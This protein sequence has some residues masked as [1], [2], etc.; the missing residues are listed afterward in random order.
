[1]NLASPFLWIP[2]HWQFGVWVLLTMA[3]LAMGNYLQRLGIELNQFLPNGIL[4]LEA[5]GSTQRANEILK[6]LGHKGI[7]LARQQT[8]ADFLFL[9]LYPLA[10]SLACSL[11]ASNLPGSIGMIG[12]M[13]AWAILLA[14][15]L[16]ATENLAILRQ[17]SGH[18][19]APWPQLAVACASIKF[20]LVTG[21]L[22]FT[23]GGFGLRLVHYLG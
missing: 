4:D 11:L 18:T 2:Q 23:I 21:G 9:L 1:M 16:D 3:T 22:G 14:I 8:Q 7:S 12:G 5:S 10:I 6:A 20:T 19:E 15:P 17:L 13:I